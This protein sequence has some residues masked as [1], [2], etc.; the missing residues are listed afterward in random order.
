[1]TDEQSSSWIR[2]VNAIVRGDQL[3]Y[4]AIRV[5]PTPILLQK[6]GLAST[7]LVM[8]SGKIATARREHPEVG[9]SIWHQLPNLLY[10]P[11]AIFPSTRA[12]GSIIVVLIVEDV[13]GNPII[14]PIL[15]GQNGSPNVIL[16]LYGKDGGF[17][18]IE[19]Q[20]AQHKNYG[21]AVYEKKG[22]IDT[23]PKPGSAEA[24][25]SSPGPIPADGSMKP[26]RNIL[27]I[28]KKSI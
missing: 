27:S 2:S 22:S 18:W 9:L 25:P 1:M 17:S 10:D 15:P 16:S 4:R 7:Q 13:D 19:N 6:F 11:L 8:S 21:A 5:G 23:E 14:V 12:D 3:N 20:I 24:I 26:N 28:S